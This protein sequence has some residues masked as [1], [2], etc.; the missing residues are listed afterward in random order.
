M[1]VYLV[2]TLGFD[3]RALRAWALLAWGL[4]LVC[5]FFMPPP[6]PEP[7][8]T[9]VNINYVSAPRRIVLLAMETRLGVITPK[10]IK[11]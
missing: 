7:G 6:N 2:W 1:L 10:H 4:L 3:R 11:L 8:L 5:F 9:P